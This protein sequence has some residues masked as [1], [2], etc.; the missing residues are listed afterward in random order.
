MRHAPRGPRQGRGTHR[1]A[2]YPHGKRLRRHPLHV[3][4]RGACPCRRGQPPAVCARGCRPAVA[5]AADAAARLAR[6]DRANLDALD[7]RLLDLAGE[8]LGDRVVRRD[9]GFVAR[10]VENVFLDDAAHDAVAER[11]EDLAALDDRGHGDA[12]DRLAV[13][14]RDDDVLGDIDEAAREIAG[15]GRLERRVGETLAGAVRRDEVLEDGEALAEVGDDGLLHDLARGLGHGA[16]HARELADLLLAAAGAGVGHHVDGVELRAA[17]AVRRLHLLEHGLR[18]R[19]RDAMPDVD[20]LVVAF[21]VRDG[22]LLALVLDLEHVLAG[23]R[24]E[25]G[26]RVG[27]VHVVDADRDAGL[28]RHVEADGLDDVEDLDRALEPV[29]YETEVDEVLQALLL[30]RSVQ[31]R[32]FGRKVRRQENAPDGRLDARAIAGD[33]V[34]VDD[35]LVVEDLALEV[36]EAARETHRDARVRVDLAGLVREDDLVEAREDAAFSLAAVLAAGQVVEA[37]DEVL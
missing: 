18:H 34:G 22:A 1:G 4:P 28:R 19:L 21:A 20:D 35:V 11:L 31:E 12:V 33:R 9:E 13:F 17:D 5:L 37:E 16:A 15:V 8:L 29:M 10:R 7:A 24:D 36:D 27:N 30:E 3:P 14:L 26:L 23:T 32:Q 25:L 2:Q 6:E